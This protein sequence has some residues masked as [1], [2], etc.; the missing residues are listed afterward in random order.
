M[1]AISL[2]STHPTQSHVKVHSMSNLTGPHDRSL[3]SIAPLL[4][5]FEFWRCM[6]FGNAVDKVICGKE[7]KLTTQELYC[8]FQ[9]HSLTRGSGGGNGSPAFTPESYTYKDDGGATVQQDTLVPTGFTTQ[10]TRSDIL[11]E[12]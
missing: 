12:H 1:Q 5:H 6:N 9:Q 8:D 4:L 3:G 10:S 11:R 7:A 2:R